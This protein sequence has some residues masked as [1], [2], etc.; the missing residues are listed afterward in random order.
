M[1]SGQPLRIGIL[2]SG[3]MLQKYVE[4]F[5]LINDAALVAVASHTPERATAV[6]GQFNIPRAHGSYETLVR[7]PEIDIVINALHNGLHC[8]WSVHALDANK[9]VLCEKPLGCSSTEVD[10][11]FAAAHGARRWLMEGLMYRFHPQISEMLRRIRAGEIG[12]VLHV[13]SSRAAHGRERDNPRFWRN[14]GGG[15]LLDLGCYCVNFARLI[16]NAEPQRVDATA[17]FDSDSGVDLT[18]SGTLEFADGG[19]A[20]FIC[21]FESEPSYAAEV[22]GTAGKMLVPHPWLPPTWPAEFFITRGGKTET[23]RIDAPENLDTP[24][25]SYALQLRHFCECIR[26]NCPPVFP[27]DFDAERDSRAN[28]RVLD[29]L[30][31]ATRR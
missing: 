9:H 28:M 30:A 29:A 21:S 24:L 13:H 5:R 27:P 16:F 22:L 2:G 23:V 11:M 3:W 19:T 26:K 8:Q 6:A 10:T 12:R 4:V 1:Q 15:A 17:H 14:A 7:D 25:A 31:A 20:Q 18:T